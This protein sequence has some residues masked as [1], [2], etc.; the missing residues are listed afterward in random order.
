M[1]KITDPSI[2]LKFDASGPGGI[3]DGKLTREDFDL[4]DTS[5]DEKTSRAVVANYDILIKYIL[6]GKNLLLSKQILSHHMHIE[7]MNSYSIGAAE[8]VE[9]E[10]EVLLNNNGES[11]Q[12]ELT[13]REKF[14]KSFITSNF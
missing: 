4:S 1:I 9:K 12:E 3:E 13:L 5:V 8:N 14:M 2:I 6:S 10:E 7:A 11:S